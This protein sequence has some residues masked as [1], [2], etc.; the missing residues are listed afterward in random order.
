MPAMGLTLAGAEINPSPQTDRMTGATR[1]GGEDAEEETV[2]P[3]S[4]DAP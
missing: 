1:N 2:A 4:P 3:P